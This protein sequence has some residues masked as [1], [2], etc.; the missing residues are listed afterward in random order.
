MGSGTRILTRPEYHFPA[1]TLQNRK[2]RT[3]KY[4][5]LCVRPLQEK[6]PKNFLKG[7]MIMT[8]ILKKLYDGK[9]NP[10]ARLMSLS[11]DYQESLDKASEAEKALCKT[12]GEEQERLFEEYQR[13]EYDL[14][15]INLADKFAY[16]FRLGLLMAMEA[17]GIKDQYMI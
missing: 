7:R 2:G 5:T 11:L 9:I 4:Y 12:F 1:G 16:G 8:D 10:G 6:G 3:H 13:L 15:E 17:Y 14:T